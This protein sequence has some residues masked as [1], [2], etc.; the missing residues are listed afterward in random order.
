MLSEFLHDEKISRQKLLI[1][2]Q[3]LEQLSQI[4]LSTY[5]Q[6]VKTCE[7]EKLY[8]LYAYLGY[9]IMKAEIDRTKNHIELLFKKDTI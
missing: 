7:I 8:E 5:I 9:F 4:E 6:F 2:F 1:F 3:K